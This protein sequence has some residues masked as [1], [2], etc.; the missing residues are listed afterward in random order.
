M[1]VK[2]NFGDADRIEQPPIGAHRAFIVVLPGLV[3]GFDQVIVVA[4]LHR[5]LDEIAHVIGLVGERRLGVDPRA[6]FRRP[7]GFADHDRLVRKLLADMA[8]RV[9]V[10]HQRIMHRHA[11]PIGQQMDG[12]EIDIAAELGI[13]QPGRPRF[14]RRH[15]D[16]VGQCRA[17]LP[18]ITVEL[19]GGDIAEQD[20]LVADENPVDDTAVGERDLDGL[21]DLG[22]VGFQIGTDP[23]PERDGHAVAPGDLRHTVQTVGDGVGADMGRQLAQ[24]RHVAVDALRGDVL[25]LL[26]VEQVAGIVG[27]AA[28]LAVPV[29]RDHPIVAAGPEQG[30][31]PH[32]QHQCDRDPDP[33][34]RQGAKPVADHL[35]GHPSCAP[36]GLCRF[37]MVNMNIANTERPNRHKSRK[38]PAKNSLVEPPGE[39][40]DWNHRPTVPCPPEGP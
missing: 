26:A 40:I 36:A 16:A 21:G 2:G 37:S 9:L 11:F 17:D 34:A 38:H 32:D 1:P 39:F 35:P 29:G 12:D 19:L 6:A 3:I 33:A 23:D 20:R 7:A 25:G 4:L 27:D 8:H 10:E 13:E 30:R 14:G 28:D 31:G 5:Q 22:L 18:D 24:L 15:L